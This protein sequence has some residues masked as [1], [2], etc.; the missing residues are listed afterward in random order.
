MDR[1]IQ[2]SQIIEKLFRIIAELDARECSCNCVIPELID[3]S[4][5]ELCDNAITLLEQLKNKERD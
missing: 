2:E 5:V 3:K 4:F 1:N